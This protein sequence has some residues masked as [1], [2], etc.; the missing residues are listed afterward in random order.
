MVAHLRNIPTLILTNPS[1]LSKFGGLDEGRSS[2]DDPDAW[3]GEKLRLLLQFLQLWSEGHNNAMQQMMLKQDARKS[4]NLVQNV[5]SNLERLTADTD[6][7]RGAT[8]EGLD[9]LSAI[10]D[11]LAEILQG[12]CRENQDFLVHASLVTYLKRIIGVLHNRYPLNPTTSEY[13][14]AEKLAGK[15][16]MASLWLIVQG[17]SAMIEGRGLV[18]HV[19]AV[20]SGF[21]ITFFCFFSNFFSKRG[22][23]K[24]L[25]EG[26]ISS[27]MNASLFRCIFA[28]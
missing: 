13:E 1:F 12:P 10:C 3:A 18:P 22:T 19:V 25:P 14:G 15:D 2:V 7:L 21:R 6:A 23:K 4:Y 17:L 5:V 16:I 27:G 11:F 28:A 9:L 20:I 8:N 26:M 24:R